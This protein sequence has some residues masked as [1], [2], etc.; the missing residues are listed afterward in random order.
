MKIIWTFSLLMIPGVLSSIS[1]TGYSG[2]GAMITCKYDKGYETNAKYFCKGEWSECTDK[3]KTGTKDTWFKSGRFSLYDDTTAAVFTV[4][5]RDLTEQDSDIY[6]C[7]TDIYAKVDSATEVNL[8]VI[9]GPKISTVRGYAGGTVIIDYEYG[10]QHKYQQKYFCK[11]GADQC[12]QIYTSKSGIQFSIDDDRSAG[13]L[14]VL[15]EELKQYNSGKYC[16]VVR[17]SE[18]YSL[19]SEFELVITDAAC[20]QKSISLSAA[21]G[22]SV[23]I[24]C[25]YPQSHTAD[26]KFIC[27]RSGADLCAKETRSEE[28][29][30][31]RKAEG[32]IR[33]YDD[34]EEQ[35]LTA[36]ISHESPEHSA[37]YWCGVQSAGHKSFITRVII[38]FTD[39]EK[40]SPQPS[41]L[42]S[43]SSS[44]PPSSSLVESP[45]QRM[46]VR[47]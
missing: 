38:S 43:S 45:L 32:K 36:T 39:A 37:E 3:I 44:P 12:R 13:L 14:H 20:C 47:K 15:I 40:T 9:T 42:P 26:V 1:V 5:I 35:L 11:C 22:G 33:L 28:E 24:S 41:S 8:K 34:R 23:N 17:A 7:G 29:S 6:Y 27:R 16:I 4:T 21:A 25:K 10:K 46:C 31:G 30:G 18:D 2:G 19:F